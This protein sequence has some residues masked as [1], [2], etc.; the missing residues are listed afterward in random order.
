VRATG[1]AVTVRT[2]GAGQGLP[3]GTDVSAYRIIQEAL[4]NTI[5]HARATTAEVSLHFHPRELIIDI[6]DDGQPAGPDAD[7]APRPGRGIIGMRERVSLYG[8]N[9]SAGPCPGGGFQ[10]HARFPLPPQ[11]P[12]P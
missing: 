4:T 1:L 10:V 3:T 7:G 6:L 12:P 8:G 2:E 5:K 11:G 9:L